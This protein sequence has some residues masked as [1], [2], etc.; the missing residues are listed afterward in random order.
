MDSEQ[1]TGASGDL[2]ERG[3]QYTMDQWNEIMTQTEDYVRANPSKAVLYGVAAGFIIDRLPVFRIFGV[4]VR[5]LLMALKPAIL[6]YGATKLY[7]IVQS[8]E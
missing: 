3:I 7:Q 6:V 1:M 8:D 2:A 4:F 5:L